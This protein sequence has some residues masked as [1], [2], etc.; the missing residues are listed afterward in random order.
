MKR[1]LLIVAIIFW[2]ASA[3]AANWYVDNSVS[4]SG[5]GT[6]WA[7]AWKNISNIS[8]SSVN[9]G[10]TVYISGGTSSQTYNEALGTPKS[11]TS[12][13]PVTISTGQDAGHNGIVIFN[14]SGT[15]LTGN[16]NYVNITGDVGGANN[17]QVNVTGAN[18]AWTS[19]GSVSN[20]HLSYIN[21]PKM[22]GGFRFYDGSTASAIEM[23]HLYIYKINSNSGNSPYDTTFYFPNSKNGYD[24][25]IR[26]HDNTWYIPAA[27]NAVGDDGSEGGQ[28]L[29]FYNN[30]IIVYLVSNYVGGQHSDV[31][32]TGWSY[33]KIYN[34]TFVDVGESIFYHD[35]YQTP[36]N[37][38]GFLFFNNLVVATRQPGTAARILDLQ[39]ESNG[40]GTTFTDFFA[41]S[42]TIVDYTQD[43]FLI[44]YNN[45]KSYTNCYVENNIFYNSTGGTALDPGVIASNNT[46]GNVQFVSYSLYGGTNNNLHLSASDTVAKDKGATLT[47]LAASSFSLSLFAIDKDGVSRPQGSAWDIGAYEYVTSSTGGT[48][49]IPM[50]PSLSLVN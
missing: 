39:P 17:M 27:A 16:M 21:F 37:A 30:L 23:D 43:V 33:Y 26:F 4:S 19:S 6:S 24:G 8:W 5:D 49:A 29:S 48:T 42:N 11:G 40:V 2:A 15:W 13:S 36:F 3:H 38:V 22:A 34:N 47:N 1:F 35:Q 50:P 28:G 44:R 41:V 7:T 12:G 25:T 10:D 20:V 32:Q 9:P 45:A 18:L 14:P 31:F 46:T